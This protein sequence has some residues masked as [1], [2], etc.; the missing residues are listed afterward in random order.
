MVSRSELDD[1]RED[2]RCSLT[3]LTFNSKPII[4]NLTVIAQEN[5]HAAAVIAKCLEEHI[6][7]APPPHKLPAL[8]LLDSICKNIGTPYTTYFGRNLYR[9]FMEAYT[10]V[11]PSTRRK[12]EE[13][14]HTWKQP[15]PMSNSHSP[16]FPFDVTRPIENALIKAKTLLLQSS[17]GIYPPQIHHPQQHLHSPA[18]R[19]TPPIG[20]NGTY[21]SGVLRLDGNPNIS[22][23][24]TVR[25]TIAETPFISLQPVIPLVQHAADILLQDIDGYLAGVDARLI[26]NPH[27]QVAHGQRMALT[28]L[29]ALVRSA[30]LPPD[31]LEVVRTQL[32]L[33]GFSKLAPNVASQSEAARPKPSGGVDNLLAALQQN[34]LITAQNIPS[35]APTHPPPLSSLIDV[36]LQSSS[37]LKS[38]PHLIPMLFSMMPL[39]CRT[40]GQRFADAESGRKDRDEHLDWHFRINKK[41]REARGQSRTWYVTEEEWIK[42]RETP[43]IKS[44]EI[45]RKSPTPDLDASTRFIK[46]PISGSTNTSCLICKESFQ[47]VW[48]DPTE[49]WVW[50]NAVKI[51]NTVY[52]ATCHKD[53]LREHT[54]EQTILGKRKAE[55][56][57]AD[58]P[59]KR[60]EMKREVMV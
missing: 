60:I 5:M 50:K 44:D 19:T 21:S 23:G 12:F 18:P 37:L 34:G 59:S 25:D 52:H 48:N 6:N 39:Q 42:F 49:D 3:E 10:L 53:S 20:M 14:L 57:V 13:L 51:G 28:D 46:A 9:T 43:D 41:L 15:M 30:A 56:P 22:G 54:P 4:T 1:I 11:D 24:V 16:V 47:T 33:Q 29:R 32:A 45:T 26:I 55:P 31:Q 36:E 8:Y 35:L 27:D 38:R 7:R 58:I 17:Q 2:Y 40:C